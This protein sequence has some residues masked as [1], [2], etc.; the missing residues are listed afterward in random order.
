MEKVIVQPEKNSSSH[1]RYFTAVYMISAAAILITFLALIGGF[2]LAKNYACADTKPSQQPT[3]ENEY[4]TSRKGEKSEVLVDKQHHIG[5]QTFRNEEGQT[6]ATVVF[7]FRTRLTAVRVQRTETCYLIGGIPQDMGS[8]EEFVARLSDKE[9]SATDHKDLSTN[10][11]NVS[12]TLADNIPVDGETLLTTDMLAE[13]S[14]SNLFWLQRTEDKDFKRQK[15]A[16]CYLLYCKY[17]G[18]GRYRCYW[19]CRR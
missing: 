14:R 16:I 11:T 8:F 17:I 15:R 4:S 3:Y 7:N 10:T 19:L 9:D 6:T 12:Y 13:C 1:G 18:Y 2:F 5:K